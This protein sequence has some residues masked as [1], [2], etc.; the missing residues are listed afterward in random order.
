M[1]IVIDTF[2]Y[3]RNEDYDHNFVSMV[4]VFFFPM[5]SQCT[6]ALT[7]FTSVLKLRQA[8]Q[9]HNHQLHQKYIRNHTMAVKF[10]TK[11]VSSFVFYLYT[12]LMF[13]RQCQ[14]S[15]CAFLNVAT[16]LDCQIFK[17]YLSAKIIF[18]SLLSP[19]SSA[20]VRLNP[21]NQDV[22]LAT[23]IGLFPIILIRRESFSIILIRRD[24][25]Q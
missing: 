1:L 7:A 8:G 24:F 13:G 16:K 21:L 15:E 3:F 14:M 25:S 22:S 10:C 18:P 6:N 20:Q 23:F 17:S 2:L 12:T 9:I 5:P 11:P 19:A 4:R